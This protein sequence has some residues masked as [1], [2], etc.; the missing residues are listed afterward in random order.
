MLNP[1]R[2]EQI[3]QIDMDAS[4]TIRCI[5]QFKTD[6]QYT[7]TEIR[8]EQQDGQDATGAKRWVD[9]NI[10]HYPRVC[11]KLADLLD[12][13]ARRNRELLLKEKKG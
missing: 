6:S 7:E 3:V 1:A 4:L 8:F 12:D 13:V 11:E 2:F 9:M 5:R 10:A